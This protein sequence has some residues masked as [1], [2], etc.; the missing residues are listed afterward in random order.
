MKSNS[1]GLTLLLLILNVIKNN[2]VVFRDSLGQSFPFWFWGNFNYFFLLFFSTVKTAARNDD[3]HQNNDKNSK[4]QK[5]L[6]INIKNILVLE[7]L[8]ILVQLH[9]SILNRIFIF[10]LLLSLGFFIFLKIHGKNL[11]KDL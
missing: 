8:W 9:Y 5:G 10:I 3:N 2:R 4:E 6:K 11:P 7:S 1:F